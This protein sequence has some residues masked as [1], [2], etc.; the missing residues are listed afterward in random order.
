MEIQIRIHILTLLCTLYY[1][2]LYHYPTMTKLLLLLLLFTHCLQ[3][4][5]STVVMTKFKKQANEG[6]P[7]VQCNL[8]I[9]Y[10]N[11][12]GVLMDKTRAVQWFTKAANQGDPTA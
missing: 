6:D 3:A 10:S 2:Y 1:L 8:G 7:T 9:M 11:G 12:D 5:M 4:Q